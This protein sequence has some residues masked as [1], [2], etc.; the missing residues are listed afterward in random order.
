M[1][2]YFWDFQIEDAKIYTPIPFGEI[3][4]KHLEGSLV[5]MYFPFFPLKT[6]YLGIHQTSCGPVEALA[7]LELKTPLVYTLVPQTENDVI[8]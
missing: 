2:N 5:Y 6:S 7:F 3:P 4:R 1:H 8:S